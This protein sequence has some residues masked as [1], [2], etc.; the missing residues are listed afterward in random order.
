M[1]MIMFPPSRDIESLP[2]V[3]V[4]DFRLLW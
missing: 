1:M 2:Y 3:T 4:E